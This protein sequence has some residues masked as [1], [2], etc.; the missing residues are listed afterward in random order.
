V[1]NIY[2]DEA[3]INAEDPATVVVGLV[4]QPD[5]Q[6][7]PVLRR[8]RQ[9]WDQYVPAHYRNGFVF[10]TLQVLNGRRWSNWPEEK[11]RA[12][13]TAMMRIPWEFEIPIAIGVAKRGNPWQ[14]WPDHLRKK[15][16]PKNSDHMIAFLFCM[17]QADEYIRERCGSEVAQIIAAYTGEMRT[18]LQKTANI[19]LGPP[20]TLTHVNYGP[21]GT[22]GKVEEVRHHTERVIDEVHF[23]EPKNAPFLQVADVCAFALRRYLSSYEDGREY[24]Q[25]M[26]GTDRLEMPSEWSGFRGLIRSERQIKLPW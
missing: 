21:K 14:G 11:R 7:F 20:L 22:V 4:V 10:H 18:V 3:G 16:T 26:A 2:T 6:W 24:L 8:I 15:M 12:L 19:M 1:R 9:I 23:L 25:V 13:V 5:T 17:S